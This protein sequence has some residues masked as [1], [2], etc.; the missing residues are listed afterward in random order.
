MQSRFQP[1]HSPPENPSPWQMVAQL[2]LSFMQI[3][4]YWALFAS[5]FM[6][7]GYL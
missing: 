2:A 3:S 4:L 7:R 1:L 6:R 5:H